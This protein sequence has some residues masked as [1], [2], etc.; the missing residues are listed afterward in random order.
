LGLWPIFGP[1]NTVGKSLLISAKSSID[2]L[3]FFYLLELES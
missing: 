2:M 1:K 3:I